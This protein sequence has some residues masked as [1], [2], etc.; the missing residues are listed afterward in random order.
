M[1]KK[2]TTNRKTK[3]DA[4]KLEVRT[5]FLSL[6]FDGEN[7]SQLH[8]STVQ[9]EN[10]VLKLDSCKIETNLTKFRNRVLYYF[11]FSV[12]NMINQYKGAYWRDVS[13]LHVPATYFFV[14]QHL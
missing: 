4:Q 2:A 9:S 7:C 13:Q 8:E 5:F 3:M 6:F 14:F 1:H 10:S 11:S 12:S